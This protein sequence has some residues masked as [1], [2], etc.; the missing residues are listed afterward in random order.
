MMMCTSKY[1]SVVIENS[2]NPKYSHYPKVR[3]IRARLAS[4]VPIGV[5]DQTTIMNDTSLEFLE[6]FT[7]I[8]TFKLT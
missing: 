3:T 7:P 2:G 4:V 6:N 5:N 1:G 8:M